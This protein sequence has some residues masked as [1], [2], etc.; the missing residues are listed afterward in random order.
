MRLVK[1]VESFDQKVGLDYSISTTVFLSRAEARLRACV[2]SVVRCRIRNH[3]SLIHP[4]KV[5][6]SALHIR[7]DQLNT[8]PV[9]DVHAFKT[10]H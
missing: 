8:E 10:A 6:I 4:L 1:S 2:I 3:R 7:A 9:A 5:D